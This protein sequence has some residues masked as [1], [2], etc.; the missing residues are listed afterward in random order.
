MTAIFGQDV[1]NVLQVA[2]S[3]HARTSQQFQTKDWDVTS[4]PL[5]LRGL[6][7]TCCLAGFTWVHVEMNDEEIVTTV[8]NNCQGF[9]RRSSGTPWRRSSGSA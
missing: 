4:M 6:F 1:P 8:K 2:Q 9:W 7:S 3:L 5:A